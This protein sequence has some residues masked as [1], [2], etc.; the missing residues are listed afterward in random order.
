M[1]V[2]KIRKIHYTQKAREEGRAEG[3]EEGRKEEKI[4]IAKSLLDILDI[5]IIAGKTGLTVEEIE[6][7]KY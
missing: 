2:D 4:K 1:S 3:R 7:F 6:K 5:K